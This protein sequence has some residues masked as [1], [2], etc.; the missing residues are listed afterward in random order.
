MAVRVEDE[1]FRCADGTPV[2]VSC[3]VSPMVLGGN[4]AG[5]VVVFRKARERRLSRDG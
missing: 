4:P 5:A 3:Q 1:V 2:R